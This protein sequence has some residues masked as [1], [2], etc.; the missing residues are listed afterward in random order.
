PILLTCNLLSIV[1]KSCVL[2]W[3]DV[4]IGVQLRCGASLFDIGSHESL[5]HG[6]RAG[7]GKR[8]TLRFSV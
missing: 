3:L 1:S 6:I 5:F 7:F 4:T 8:C 2:R